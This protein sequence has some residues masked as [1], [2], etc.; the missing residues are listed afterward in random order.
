MEIFLRNE[1]LPFP[2]K[3]RGC[4]L[5]LA[6]LV[7]KRF[8]EADLRVLR[9]FLGSEWRS[10]TSVEL[11]LKKFSGQEIVEIHWFG[12]KRRKVTFHRMCLS[13]GVGQVS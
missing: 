7:G 5:H 10:L 1:P 2:T 11:R 9:D 3:E 8:E 4:C 13:M 6:Q 12:A